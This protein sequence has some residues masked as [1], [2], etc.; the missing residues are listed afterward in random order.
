MKLF[1]NK[2]IPLALTVVMFGGLLAGCSKSTET[3]A[4]S[5]ASSTAPTTAPTEAATDAPATPAPDEK[6]TLT[7]A[8]QSSDWSDAAQQMMDKFTELHPNIKIDF[9]QIPNDTSA[10][11]LQPK[12][13]ANSLPDLFTIDGGDFGSQL[14]E[15]GLIADLTN[16][17]AGKDVVDGLKGVFTS[18]SGKLFGIAGGLST[19]LIYYNKKLFEQAG[20]TTMPQNWEEFLA[21]CEILK[22]KGI[23]PL[24]VAGGDGTINNTIWSTGFADSVI[25]KDPEAVKKITAGTFDF[26]T[27]EYADVFTKA[28]TLYDKGYLVKGVVSLM[29]GQS[30]DLFMQ[31]K[32]AMS[33]S[34]IWLAGTMMKSDFGTGV[35]MAPWNMKDQAKVPI[36]ATETGFGV[37]E[38]KH[39]DAAI[40]L[41]NF[42]TMGEGYYIYQNKK[43]NIPMMK[44]TDESKIKIDPLI[45]TYIKDSQASPVTGP[46]WFEFLPSEVQSKLVQTFQRVFTGE[47]TPDAAAKFTDDTYKEAIK[48][49][50]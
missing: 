21:D 49:K 11:Y 30:N 27:P 12:A 35:F 13:A 17:D 2:M 41:L 3:P 10:E 34:G 47:L 14:A 9:S 33:F 46:L 4:A 5:T 40:Q 37:A 22:G 50:K 20:I 24:T 43:G 18:K 7:V 36:L 19:S 28:K 8:M 44:A 29:Y 31:G 6:I 25:S 15:N 26:N 16:T 48:N 1:T 39:K 38:G 42:M 45:S 23:T 32:A